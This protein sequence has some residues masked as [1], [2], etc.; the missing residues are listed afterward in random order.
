MNI[1]AHSHKLFLIKI[2]FCLIFTIIVCSDTISQAFFES[3]NQSVRYNQNVDYIYN[4]LPSMKEVD[5]E[6]TYSAKTI[7]VVNQQRE[8][9]S[10]EKID[11]YIFE[12]CDFYPNVET[13][14]VQSL[15]EKESNYNPDAFNKM[16]PWIGLMQIS[17]KWHKDRMDRLGVS[18]LF[19]P[20]GNILVGVDYLDELINQTNG[21]VA[22]AL[23]IYN[24]GYKTANDMYSQGRVSAYARDI[25]ERQKT[26]KGGI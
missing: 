8:L 1:L 15:I 10:K 6:L 21:D 26:L 20:Y 16:G 25:L 7:Q 2:V 18:D 14:L 19:N 12:V 9:S 5:K 3:K 4:V 13:T 23:M 11:G 22:F 17:P 24:M